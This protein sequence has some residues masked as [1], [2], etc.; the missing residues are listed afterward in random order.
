[1]KKILV[2]LSATLFCT[3]LSA[4]NYISGGAIDKDVSTGREGITV[5]VKAKA[6]YNLITKK[7]EVYIATITTPY[8]VSVNMGGTVSNVLPYIYGSVT[9]DRQT[10]VFDVNHNNND[11]RF[12]TKLKGNIDFVFGDTGIIITMPVNCEVPKP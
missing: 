12:Y 4:Q 8:N 6:E 11:G 1:M 9:H 7:L 10:F 5:G 3:V 2:L